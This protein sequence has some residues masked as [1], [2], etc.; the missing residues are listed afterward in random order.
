M[1][2]CSRRCAVLSFGLLVLSLGCGAGDDLPPL[3]PVD[4][5]VT[6]NGQGVEGAQVLFSPMKGPTSLG[7][8]DA[9][10]AFTLTVSGGKQPG[11]VVGTHTVKVAM[12]MQVDPKAPTGTSPESQGPVY[13]P[14][15]NYSFPEGVRVDA[16]TNNVELSL[17]KA[18]KQV[19]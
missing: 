9:N 13:L 8:T 16:G 19:G 14:P 11:A 17:E 5:R 18:K 1:P 10:G 7:T 2:L 3:A 15:V 4:G 12:P 6:L